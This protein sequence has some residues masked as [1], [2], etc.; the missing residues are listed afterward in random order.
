MKNLKI[1]IVALV[2]GYN[3]FESYDQ[4]IQRNKYLYENVKL[5]ANHDYSYIL[6][7]EGNISLEGQEYI[8]EKTKFEI[9]F[10]DVKTCFEISQKLEDAALKESGREYANDKGYRLMC[11]FN[12]FY[13]WSYVK[14]FDYILRVDED[15]LIE[16]FDENQFD[17]M[18]K[19]KIDF[20]VSQYSIETHSYTN[21]SLP[22]F[23][24]KNLNAN[25]DSFYNHKFPYTNVYISRVN[26]WL[27]PEINKK[28]ENIALSDE[29]YIYRWGDLPILG[30]Y[31]NY[32]KSKVVFFN[33]LQYKHL[34]HGNNVKI[35]NSMLNS[36][37][38]TIKVSVMLSKSYYMLKKLYLKSKLNLQNFRLM[39]NKLVTKEIGTKN[40]SNREGWL[41]IKLSNLESGIS[42]LDA[43]AGEA[44]YKTY[45]SHLKYTSQD[46][47]K[48]D[49]QGD[50][51]G[52]QTKT[53]D[54]SEIDIISDIANI[55]LDNESFD[56]IMCIEVFEHL[57]NPLDALKEFNRILKSGGMLILTAPFN[58]L[59]HYA[60]YHFSTGF[61]KYFYEHHLKEFEFEII[62]LVENGSYFEYLAQEARRLSSVGKQYSNKKLNFFEKLISL[63]YLR[64][65]N[66][67]SKSDTG[68]K[69]ILNFGIQILA[70]KK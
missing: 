37:Y 18:Y 32:F 45:C 65:L 2:R 14:K 27:E 5:K 20:C 39:I 66:K 56:A 33:F 13:I 57:T 1:G 50:G 41:K 28:L 46:I 23:L 68:S 63:F 35:K 3:N 30:S 42:I 11:R 55:P 38:Q 12:T 64:T 70:Q 21:S 4:L 16:K 24:V 29:Q 40:G 48:Y 62:E 10:I 25:D 26:F 67:L 61:T 36:I 31:L 22:S 54:Y 60:P 19:S 15:C 53:R 6:F 44:Q 9:E 17:I 49:G 52:L 51:H 58:S 7:H 43:G 69:D 59:T 34:S 47:A 8:Q